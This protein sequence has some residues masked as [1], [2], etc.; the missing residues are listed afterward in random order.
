M[1]VFEKVALYFWNMLIAAFAYFTF[2]YFY[3]R[4]EG[5]IG[6]AHCLVKN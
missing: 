6:A 3:F 4:L 1:F 2:F 5:R